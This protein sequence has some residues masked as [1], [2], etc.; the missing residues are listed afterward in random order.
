MTG[1]HLFFLCFSVFLTGYGINGHAVP[2]S[3][4]LEKLQAQIKEEQQTHRAL[5]RKA[6][7]VATEVSGVQKKMVKAAETVQDFEETLTQLEKKR[8]ELTIFSSGQPSSFSRAESVS[9]KRK[10][11]TARLLLP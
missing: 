5:Q 8:A 4:D 1:R 2:S 9:S 6:Q 3:D 7:D 10:T 11:R